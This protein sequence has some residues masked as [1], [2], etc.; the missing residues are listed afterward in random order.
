VSVWCVIVL[1]KFRRKIRRILPVVGSLP[2]DCGRAHEVIDMAC[3]YPVSSIPSLAAH[4][5]LQSHMSGGQSGP[6]TFK[7]N[8]VEQS[9]VYLDCG[10][11]RETESAITCIQS[12]LSLSFS[13]DVS[14][15]VLDRM[16][17]S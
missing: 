7:L 17:D 6:N 14:R 12:P 10:K 4:D 16:S 15:I 5:R 8:A 11:A 3:R 9:D 2:Y 1:L 13:N